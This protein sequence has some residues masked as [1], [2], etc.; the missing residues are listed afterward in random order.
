MVLIHRL[1]AATR[2]RP[3]FHLPVLPN[4]AN[5]GETRRNCHLAGECFLEQL[6]PTLR[7]HH[8]TSSPRL[9]LLILN[10]LFSMRAF[11]PWSWHQTRTR[12]S[13]KTQATTQFQMRCNA[14]PMSCAE[15]VKYIT[16]SSPR[17]TMTFISSDVKQSPARSLE[18]CPL[19]VETV[20][21]TT[22]PENLVLSFFFPYNQSALTTAKVISNCL[23]DIATIY[24][25]Q[26]SLGG[27]RI[28][29]PD[30][31]SDFW[32]PTFQSGREKKN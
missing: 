25:T 1:A 30:G 15:V 13:G 5:P 26:E 8:S 29:N 21:L 2:I 14:R 20:L 27:T 4:A 12:S 23:A 6:P 19:L 9:N 22:F 10:S 17:E 7:G 18:I 24:R 31:S 28:R 3:F 32:T 16:R 11:D